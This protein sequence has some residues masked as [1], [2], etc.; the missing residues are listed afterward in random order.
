M[1]L[2]KKEKLTGF[3]MRRRV[4]VGSKS[5]HE[6]I[7]IVLDDSQAPYFEIRVKGQNPFQPAPGL[8]AFVGQR[9]QVEGTLGSGV[10][11]LLVDKVSDIV[12]LGPPGRSAKPPRPNGP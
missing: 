6:A 5:E 1:S 12:L 4:N 3:V 7:V 9:V 10:L 2:G 8:E 11:V